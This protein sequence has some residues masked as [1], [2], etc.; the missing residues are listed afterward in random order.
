MVAFV[1]A[2]YEADAGDNQLVRSVAGRYMVSTQVASLRFDQLTGPTD[3]S[4][5]SLG[6]V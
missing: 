1:R 6:F 4:Q 5:L 3:S 2:N